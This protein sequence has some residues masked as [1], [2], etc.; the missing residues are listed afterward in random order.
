MTEPRLFDNYAEDY[1]ATVQDVIGA[2][3]ESV[4]FFAALKIDL[5]QR[6]LATSAVSHIL[7]FG[8]GVGNTTREIAARFPRART[9]GYDPSGE[10][11]AVARRLPAPEGADTSFVTGDGRTLPFEDASFDAVFTACVFHHI[12][13]KDHAHWARELLRVLRP[14]GSFLIFEHN[15]FN[16]LTRRVVRD[17]PFDEGVV[18]LRPRYARRLLQSAGFT[19]SPPRFYFFYPH[20]LRALRPTERLL[21]WLPLGA[22]Y[23]VV[24]KRG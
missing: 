9:V 11:I 19:A 5:M 10:S 21:R 20:A 17:C 1:A 18:L 15:P 13:E 7:D 6:E 12:E 3:G 8:C 2:S 22:Q 24:G 14:G 16:P 4:E 23:Y